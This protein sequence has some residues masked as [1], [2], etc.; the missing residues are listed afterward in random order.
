[1]IRAF[2]WR[3]LCLALLAGAGVA[4][5][6]AVPDSRPASLETVPI[7]RGPTLAESRAASAPRNSSPLSMWRVGFA[8]AVVLGAIFALRWASRRMLGLP[9]GA[10]STPAVR[11][12]GRSIIAPRQQVLL[13]QVGRRVLVV[14]NSGATMNSLC[15]ITDPDE[16]AAILGQA[17]RPA[18]AGGAFASAFAQASTTFG[19]EPQAIGARATDGEGTADAARTEINGLLEKVRTLSRSFRRA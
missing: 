10:G 5:A 13:L 8:L 15:E 16:V 11:V 7:R 12:V 3:L 17:S 2:A 14:A 4:G 19:E 9:P 6:D 18:Q 1:M